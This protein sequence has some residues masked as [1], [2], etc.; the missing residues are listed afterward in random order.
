MAAV[1][2]EEEAN[3]ALS[4]RHGSSSREGIQCPTKRTGRAWEWA[5]EVTEVTEQAIEVT[6][7]TEHIGLC[8]PHFSLT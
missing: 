5:V 1:R 4:E 8:H 3:K 6:E 2:E 7:V